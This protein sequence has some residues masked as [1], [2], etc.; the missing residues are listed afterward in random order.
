[1]IMLKQVLIN[2]HKS[3]VKQN[4]EYMVDLIKPNPGAKLLDL[5]CDRG[6]ITLK[7]GRKLRTKQLYGVEVVPERILEAKKNGVQ[8]KNFDLNAPFKYEKNTFDVIFSNQVIEHLSD[9]DNFLSE[10]YRILKPGGYA[11]ISTENAS[12]WENIFASIMGWQIFSFTNF[13][14]K[15]CGVGNPL[16]INK[17]IVPPLKSWNHMKIFNFFG[18]KEIFELYNFE[19]DAIRGAGYFPLP[20]FF[21]NLDKIHAHFITFKI[22][23]PLL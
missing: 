22:R 13:S 14:V 19:I 17:D 20:A 16:A 18:L 8:V 3:A 23:K 7:L 1:M 6:D 5:G 2:L 4:F 21:G 15:R 12:A 10:I 9:T 11:I